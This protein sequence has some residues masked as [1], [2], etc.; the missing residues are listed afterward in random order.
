M[1][2]F[3]HAA[4][5][6]GITG[7]TLI[8]T[9]TKQNT[10]SSTTLVMDKPAG[11][12]E[13]D[14]MIASMASIGNQGTDF[15]SDPA[16][17]TDRYAHEGVP[18]PHIATKVAGSS[19]GTNYTYTAP[20]DPGF[21]GCILTFRNAVYDK[22]GIGATA[23]SGGAITATSINVAANG[24]LLLAFYWTRQTNGTWS[25]PSGMTPYLS[26]SNA[27]G[28]TWAIFSQEVN[29]GATGNKISDPSGSTTSKGILLAIGPA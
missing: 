8:G 11:T 3:R 6:G 18:M 29:A 16:G 2:L 27:D 17:W 28:P 14:L 21:N 25:T 10:T 22:V 13:G 23:L 1:M 20:S 5:G 4:M 19:E 15:F 12:V 26:S 7:L 9:T 24:S